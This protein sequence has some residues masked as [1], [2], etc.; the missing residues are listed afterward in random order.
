MATFKELQE[1]VRTLEFQKLVFDHLADHLENSFRS[2]AMEKPSKVLLNEEKVPVPDSI[3]ESIISMMT[4]QA[5]YLANQ[6]IVI[7][8]SPVAVAEPQA[9][10]P[11][12]V[13][14]PQEPEPKKGK[15]SKNAASEDAKQGEGK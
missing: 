11:V 4:Q 1:Q 13:P 15:K 2:K 10:G 3:F 9:Q 5:G 12:E 7:Q 6:V 14:T 8:N